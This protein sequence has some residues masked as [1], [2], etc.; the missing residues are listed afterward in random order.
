[1]S[2]AVGL[3]ILL[4]CAVILVS[5]LAVRTST[6]F[7][8]PTL[9]IYLGLGIAVGEA[10]LGVRFDNAD[11]TRTLGLSALVLILAEGG[12]STD[13]STV[14]RAVPVGAVLATLGIAISVGATAAIVVVVLGVGW[15]SGILL[16]AIVSSTDAA[17][18][19]ATLRR[20]PPRRRLAAILEVE[21][22]FNDAPAVILVITLS[23]H[24]GTLP[25]HIA[26]LVAYEL[27]AG[28]AIG[29]AIGAL[30]ALTLRRIALPVAGLYP[31]ATVSYAVL[32]FAVADVAGTCGFIAVYGC[33]GSTSM[34]CDS[35]TGRRSRS[36]FGA[37]RASFR[38]ARPG[39]PAATSC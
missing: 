35:P 6:R 4:G 38:G 7:G 21:S 10:G 1:M 22:G 37:A 3:G 2:N 33:T 30:G 31:I 29:L 28:A 24:P 12:L 39:S 32:A 18:V 11:L 8:L 5:V 36:S 17:A 16:G 19:F 13:W 20:L 15:R 14:R 25:L 34:S 27:A 9:L 26:G 23:G